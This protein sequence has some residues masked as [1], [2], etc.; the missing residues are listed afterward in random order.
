MEYKYECPQ[1]SSV[2]IL[3]KFSFEQAKK[4][5]R[6]CRSCAMKKWQLEKYGEK[7]LS[8]FTSTCPKCGKIKKHKW[9][10]LSPTQTKSRSKDLSLKM[11]KSCSN[12]EYYVLSK[13]KTNTKPERKL[14]EILQNNSINFKQSYKYEGY[15]FD[16]Y[17]IDY[18]I[19]IEVDGNY[20][21]GKGLE[22][23]K[24]NHTQKL[25]RTNDNKKSS[26]CL[27]KQQIL[28]RFWEDEIDENLVISIIQKYEKNK[29]NME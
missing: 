21:H 25:S 26:I 18:N 16:F 11:C 27:E 17:L 24:L 23:E 6:L 19:L 8:E 14:K 1:C 4:L 28:I 13:T 22:W 3:K 10:N 9:K 7:T 29:H 2:N 20:W 5:K 15:Y 12:S